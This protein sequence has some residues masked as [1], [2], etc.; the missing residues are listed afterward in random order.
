[1]I[2][3]YFFWTGL[4][5]RRQGRWEESIRNLERGI[6]LDP[7]NFFALE[8]TAVTY[9]DLRRYAEERSTH[10]RVLAF[11][12]DDAVTKVARAVVELNS[13]ADTRPL[14]QTID[15]IRATNPAAMPSIADAWLLCAL[16]E[17]DPPP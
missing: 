2:G 4:I 8:Q 16:A 6:S 11:E 12:P 7:R 15:S 5:Q 3:E 13:K 9:Q 1:M 10:D 14:H 17:R